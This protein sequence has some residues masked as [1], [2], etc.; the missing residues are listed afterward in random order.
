MKFI[1]LATL[2]ISSI[3]AWNQCPPDTSDCHLS[4]PGNSDN[5]VMDA[6]LYP[7]DNFKG[8]MKKYSIKG[9]W[10][11]V[12]IDEVGIKSAKSTGTTQL[13]FHYGKGC[14]GHVIKQV[15]GGFFNSTDPGLCAGSLFIKLNRYGSC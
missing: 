8:E 3:S 1:T 9:L 11:C 13:T 10:G 6:E 15:Q 7:E 4:P 12:D 5:V 2:A 14:S